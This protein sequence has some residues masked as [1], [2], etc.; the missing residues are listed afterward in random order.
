MPG[1]QRT[2]WV[3][4]ADHWTRAY[5][6]AELIERGHDAVGFAATADALLRLA[7]HRERP[8]LAVIDLHGQPPGPRKLGVLLHGGFPVLAIGGAVEWATPSLA[9]RPWAA[10]LH[11]PLTI[12]A[13]ADEV[14]RWLAGVTSLARAAP[15]EP[16]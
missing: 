11:R 14:E 12:G 9:A 6:R 4:G 3:I 2:I 1:N 5:L 10:R 15:P 16:H 7:L 13:I 8:A